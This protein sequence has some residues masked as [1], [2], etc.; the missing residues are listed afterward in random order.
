MCECRP[1]F[2]VCG[3]AINCAILVT[4]F[5]SCKEAYGPRRSKKNAGIS[6]LKSYM[7]AV[8]IFAAK[9]SCMPGSLF[10]CSWFVNTSCRGLEGSSEFFF[11][12]GFE[13]CMGVDSFGPHDAVPSLRDIMRE[14]G[15]EEISTS[16]VR[17]QYGSAHRWC[18]CLDRH[19]SHPR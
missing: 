15:V 9:G 16:V 4:W 8:I 17:L 6:S 3:F 11:R 13:I 12:T 2:V 5:E 18:N 14:I 10:L 1:V 19:L 7:V